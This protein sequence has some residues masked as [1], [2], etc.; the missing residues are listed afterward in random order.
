MM[1]PFD[2][3]I[4]CPTM[5]GR[6]AQLARVRRALDQVA[7]SRGQALLIAGEAGIGKSRLA[8]EAKSLAQRQGWLALEGHCFERDRVLPYAPWLDLLR[9]LIA[10]LTPSEAAEALGTEARD[11]VKLLPELT[12]QLSDL[13]PAPTLDPAHE[14]RLAIQALC[15]VVTRLSS[16]GPT[17]V[18]VEDLHWSDDTSLDALVSLARQIQGAPILLLLTYRDDEV[19]AELSHFLAT[20]DRERLASEVALSRL[21]PLDVGTMVGAIFAGA[22]AV[23]AQFRDALFTLTDGNPFF[24]EE[25]LKAL[26]SDEAASFSAGWE[27]LPPD[28]RHIPRSVQ[29]AVR[30]RV[31]R[32]S[33]DAAHLLK[34]AAVAGRRCDFILLE[35]LTTH[36]EQQLL[37]LVKELIGAQLLVEEAPDRFAFRH[38]LTRQAIYSSL[39]ARERRH[40]HRAIV[41]ALEQLHPDAA[42]SHAIELAY[43]AFE[44]GEWQRA[45]DYASRAGQQALALY[46]P[47]AAVEQFSRALDAA[48]RLS[49]TPPMQLYRQRGQAFDTLGDFDAARG[50]YEAALAAARTARDYRSEWQALLDLGLLWARRDYEQSGHYCRQALDLARTLGDPAALAYSL[51]RVGNWYTNASVPREAIPYHLEALSILDEIDDRPGIAATLDLLGLAHYVAG[52]SPSSATYYRRAVDIFRE[53]DQRQGLAWC[54]SVLAL[55]AGSYQ[56][57]AGPTA[58]MASDEALSAVERAGTIAREIEWRAGEVFADLVAGMLCGSRGSYDRAVGLLNQSMALAEQIE[59]RQWIV[60][61]RCSLG[62]LYVDLLAA[63]AGRPY[64][65]QAVAEAREMG[66]RL[67][68]LTSAAVLAA[69]SLLDADLDGADA[70]L[71]GAKLPP[72][73]ASSQGARSC[74]LVRA[75]VCLARGDAAQALRILDDLIETAPH[76]SRA[77]QV[78]ALAR[79]RGAALTRLGQ[80]EAAETALQSVRAGVEAV[81]RP[82]QLWRT[83]VALGHLYRRRRRYAEAESAYAE[84]RTIVAGLAETIPDRAVRDVF[85]RETAARIPRPREATP[86]RVAQQSFGGLT[87]REREVAALIA[88][89]KSNRAVAEQ[90]V[91]G[92]RT[93]ATHVSH[94]LAK[95]DLT[96]R[97][98]I[99]AWAID[100]GLTR[101]S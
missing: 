66:S 97:T 76:V 88:Q 65:E 12:R 19:G 33:P 60:A 94:I 40:V 31:D 16:H 96:S 52:D 15:A 55:S 90:L 9:A 45:L 92:E 98:Q 99:A 51:N 89:G 21:S 37:A 49:R 1:T 54:L 28:E 11:L 6:D 24:V 4:L 85:L 81:D 83:M 69:S 34:L 58:P 26:W 22:R 78:P 59:H 36:D 48:I 62:A 43:H 18:V 56:S 74:W 42:E 79:L 67:W 32:L 50:D 8:A 10:R 53:L 5:I 38:A 57:D 7:A 82:P 25:V 86:R 47:Q 70:V 13:A 91:V 72:I 39:L 17:L 2:Q 3:P 29:D 87:E 95:L 80:F 68:V 101:D 100:I 61:C 23:R 30:R 75:Q 63:Q 14:R 73:A 27:R 46:A 84:A 35:S 71:D 44:A 20:I 64:L 41:E 77:E 93:V